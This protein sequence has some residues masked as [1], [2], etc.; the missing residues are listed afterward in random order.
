MYCVYEVAICA[1]FP[2]VASVSGY[3]AR[4]APQGPAH[5]HESAG[6]QR[7]LASACA[8]ARITPSAGGSHPSVWA[9]RK[10]Q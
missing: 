1:I 8:T 5:T 6:K 7:R 3:L 4:V 9:T 2:Q 10:A